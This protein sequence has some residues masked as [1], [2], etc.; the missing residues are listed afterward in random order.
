MAYT[1]M[2][3]GPKPVDWAALHGA[4]KPIRK[5]VELFPVPA[6]NGLGISVPQRLRNDLAWEE[7]TQLMD[8]FKKFEMDV[9]DL[10]T[11][12]KLGADTLESVKQK[13]VVEE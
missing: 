6:S 5:R 13:F 3:E 4:V 7:I 11:G 8:V 12:T 10:A 9:Y 2:A 1:L